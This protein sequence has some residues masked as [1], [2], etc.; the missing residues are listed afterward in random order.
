MNKRIISLLLA[1]LLTLSLTAC[2][3]DT[4][5]DTTESE[6]ES[7]NKTEEIVLPD[8]SGGGEDFDIFLAYNSFDYDFIAEEETGDII[9]DLVKRRND[10]VQTKFDVNFAIRP[11]NTDN[12]SATAT[13]RS[14]VQGGDDTY[15]VFVNV[16]H[17]GVPLI[18]ENLFVNWE[19]SMPHVNLDKPW[20]YQTV[21]RD[22]NFGSSIYVAA[23]SY[24][25][26]CIRAAAALAFNKTILDEIG[27]E[28]PYKLV[29]DGEWTI[30]KMI[31][32]SKAAQSD[33]NGDGKITPDNDRLG[34]SGWKWETVPAL[35]VGMGGQP[36]VKDEYGFPL[37][38]INNERTFSVVDKMIEVFASGNG[39]WSNGSE[40]GFEDNMFRDGRLLF[41]DGTLGSLLGNVSMEDNFGV[42]PYPKLDAEQE[43]YRSR[44]VNYSS[45]TYIPVTNQKLELTSAV[46][47]YMAYL[48]HRDIIPAFYDTILEVKTVRDTESEAMVDIIRESACFMDEN[49]LTSG[50]LISLVEG[51]TNT[52]ASSYASFGESWESKL[53]EICNFWY[54]N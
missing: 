18:Y 24:N 40:Y 4:V 2:K 28:Y 47:E 3:K 30:D 5:K 11:G 23:G 19:E 54:M 49:Y 35:F 9:N 36:V 50:S 53:D 37:L 6:A 26:H 34:F 12:G 13:I 45:L 32:Y 29:L 10:D 14:L 22:L 48:S 16:Q 43:S 39:A 25:F 31:E 52:L 21:N 41:N 27:M 20:W 33:L 42:V 7:E 51:G 15:E 38:N 1:S 44:I 8:I 46:L 17:Y